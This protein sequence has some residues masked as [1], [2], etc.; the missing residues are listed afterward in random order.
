M[1]N[2]ESILNSRKLQVKDK[3]DFSANG[4][5]NLVTKTNVFVDKSLIIKDLIDHD[6]DA[7]LITRPRRWGKTTNMDMIKHFFQIDVDKYGHINS[8][9]NKNLILF[10]GG[11]LQLKQTKKL[12]PLKIAKEENGKYLEKQGSFPV[13]FISFANYDLIEHKEISNLQVLS[14]VMNSIRKAYL[15]HIYMLDLLQSKIENPDSS[16]STKE[17]ASIYKKLFLKII[18]NENITDI[19]VQNSIFTLSFILKEHFGIKVIILID[20]YDTPINC[21]IGKGFYLYTVSLFR[22]MFRAS[23]KDN[24]NVEK[25]ILTG[26]L[27]IAKADL[28]SGLN[29]FWEYGVQ[30]SKYAE[31]FGFTESEVNNLLEGFKWTCENEKKN[32]F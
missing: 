20:E 19:D 17:M 15:E 31:Y 3:Y 13:I 9:P 25:T 6:S 16:Y 8:E 22:S 10:K 4:F 29:N 28:F 21:S 5:V 11:D 14:S 7:I 30:D 18:R 26:I 1:N 32:I 12:S 2:D 23:L 24:S 27:R